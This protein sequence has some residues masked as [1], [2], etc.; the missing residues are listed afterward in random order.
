MV[1]GGSNLAPV[2]TD[3]YGARSAS[4]FGPVAFA[5][6]V[7]LRCPDVSTASQVCHTYGRG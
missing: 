7:E 4:A 2:D 6:N 1:V 5:A 3:L